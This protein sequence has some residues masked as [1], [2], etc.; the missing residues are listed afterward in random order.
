LLL[1]TVFSLSLWSLGLTLWFL[2]S[3]LAG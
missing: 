2:L 1:A 3:S